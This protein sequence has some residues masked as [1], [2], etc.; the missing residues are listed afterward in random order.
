MIYQGTVYPLFHG[1]QHTVT[2][3]SSGVEALSIRNNLSR[4]GRNE[5]RALFEHYP[6]NTNNAF[7]SMLII[8]LHAITKFGYYRM[9][10]L[11]VDSREQIALIVKQN[12]NFLKES[13]VEYCFFGYPEYLFRTKEAQ[14]FLNLDGVP[15]FKS[16]NLSISLFSW[17]CINWPPKQR[18]SLEN[19]VLLGLRHGF[20]KPLWYEV[21][22]KVEIELER[23]GTAMQDSEFASYTCKV[24]YIICDMPVEAP[25][26]S[27]NQ[28]NGLNGCTRCLL[29]GHK[30]GAMLF[31]PC[32]AEMQVRGEEERN[33]SCNYLRRF[34][35]KQQLL[36]VPCGHN[37]FMP[38][39]CR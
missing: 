7:P 11:S 36:Q 1:P 17:Q 4:N 14:L 2:E 15:I 25:A 9:K 31:D 13:W 39:L 26:L 21:L 30:S 22:S 6:L 34:L 37:Y 29:L 16:R 18:S 5:L 3:L 23:F 12:S 33:V 8:L 19:I 27:M 10:F 32:D 28:V 38:E 20:Y 35:Q 24:I